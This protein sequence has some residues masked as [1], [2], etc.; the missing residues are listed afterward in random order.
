MIRRLFTV[1]SALSLLLCMATVA[2]WAKSDVSYGHIQNGGLQIEISNGWVSLK[3]ETI[4]QA[5]RRRVPPRVLKN[6]VWDQ[7]IYPFPKTVLLTCSPW[8]LRLRCAVPAVA[9]SLLPMMS[10]ARRLCHRR[11]SESTDICR[12]CGYDLRAS[13]E[14]C[15]E[16]GTVIP[17]KAETSA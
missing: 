16:C 10:G 8:A 6:L 2:L 3:Y 14:R 13:K 5:L 4:Q 7:H 12:S 17:Q 11:K 1:A 9:L 15:P